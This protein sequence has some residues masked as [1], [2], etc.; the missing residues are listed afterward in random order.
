MN[1]QEILDMFFDSGALVKGHFLL[2]SGRHSDM[3]LQMANVFSHPV[4]CEKLSAELASRFCDEPVDVVIGPALGGV[5]LAYEVARKLNAIDMYCEREEG[6]MRLR[7]GFTIKK[8]QKVLIVEDVVTT[9]ASLNEVIELVKKAGGKIV[10]IGVVVD[11]TLGTIDFGIRMESL[12][13]LDIASF[14]ADECPMCENGEP[15][16]KPQTM[17]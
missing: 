6:R 12:A 7:R 11:R 4:C 15:L 3:Y 9:G 8:G 16:Q 5:I 17:K 2:T 1:S 14:A 13:Q 10:G